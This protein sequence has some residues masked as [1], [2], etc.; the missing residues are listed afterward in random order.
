[1]HGCRIG[2]VKLKAG[3]VVHPLPT[4]PRDTVQQNIVSRAAMI[5]G[6]YNPGE[7]RGYVVFG[8]DDKGYNSTGFMIDPD[9]PIGRTIL[10]SVV[11]DAL[12]RKMIECGE[13]ES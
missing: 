2:K 3:G 13:W 8:W 9:G 10:P 12:R 6:F 11:A 1:M 7:M 5:A 4:V